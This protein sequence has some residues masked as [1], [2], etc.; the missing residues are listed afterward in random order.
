M[1]GRR[2]VVVARVRDAADRAEADVDEEQV[3]ARADLQVDGVDAEV[4]E[5]LDLGGVG[6]PVG[7]LLHH[8]D[9]LTRVVGE[10]QRSRSKD[11]GKEPV[12]G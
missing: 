7:A 9:A 1:R 4:G 2:A 11:V 5:H 6:Q 8:P 12:C 3:A 10:E